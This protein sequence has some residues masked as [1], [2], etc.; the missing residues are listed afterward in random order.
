MTM[1]KGIKNCFLGEYTK[2]R[3]AFEHICLPDEGRE[4][5]KPSIEIFTQEVYD[6]CEGQRERATCEFQIGNREFEDS[7][8]R[9]A[10][11]SYSDSLVAL[12][13]LSGYISRGV[14]LVM[15]SELC[16]AARM[17]E[18]GWDLALQQRS[19]R[20]KAAIGIN[21][22]QVYVDLGRLDCSHKILRDVVEDCRETGDLDLKA[23]ALAHLALMMFVRGSYDEGIESCNLASEICQGGED[24]ARALFAKGVLFMAKGDLEEAQ[25]VLQEG[26]RLLKDLKYSYT[27]A[28]IRL[29][30]AHLQLLKGKGQEALEV[31][32]GALHGF[33]RILSPQGEARTIGLIAIIRSSMGDTEQGRQLFRKALALD[34]QT[35]YRRGEIRQLLNWSKISLQLGDIENACTLSQEAE[36]LALMIGHTIALLEATPLRA[37]S[38]GNISE[39]DKN[40]TLKECLELSRTTCISVG[41]IQIQQFLSSDYL[42]CGQ[43]DEALDCCRKA[44][45]LSRDLGN[46]VEQAKSHGFLAQL[47][48]QK[49]E[50]Q[51]AAEQ[52]GIA[53]AML[54]SMGIPIQPRGQVPFPN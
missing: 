25:T 51:L 7:K 29:Q 28:R 30:L 11:A 38:S 23:M 52:V 40:T 3:N 46:R 39:I 15:L 41:E 18:K 24:D 47:L 43:L 10:A 9:K 13:S 16:E 8:F 12:E 50:H 31:S 36:R 21:L 22:G 19:H 5:L 1:L 35:G 45:D 37:L 44:V 17:F 54:Q 6:A 4:F 48:D 34:R 14:S 26:T 20:F 53:E 42:G 2:S 32:K 27:D 49:G 33:Q